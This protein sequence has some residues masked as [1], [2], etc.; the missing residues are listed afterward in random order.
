[1][2]DLQKQRTFRLQVYIYIYIHIHIAMIYLDDNPYIHIAMIYLDENPYIHIAMIYLDDS[3]TSKVFTKPG[4]E[5]L[6]LALGIS[7]IYDW[8]TTTIANSH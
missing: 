3:P 8:A 5:V 4:S 2:K 6:L 7:F 1:M